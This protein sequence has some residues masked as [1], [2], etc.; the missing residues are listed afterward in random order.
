MRII[1]H[2]Y[3]PG[4]LC[5]YNEKLNKRSFWFSANNL[6]DIVISKDE[7]VEIILQWTA[8]E[9]ENAVKPFLKEDHY[10]SPFQIGHE[11]VIH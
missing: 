4:T 5:F 6:F 8:K 9:V 10:W 3:Q 2:P 11:I 7:A 1:E